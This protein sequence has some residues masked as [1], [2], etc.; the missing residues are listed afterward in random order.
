MKQFYPVLLSVPLFRG[1]KESDCEA[2]LKNLGAAIKKYPKNHIILLAGDPVDTLG[3]VLSGRVQIIKEDILGNRS[4]MAEFSAGDIFAESLACAGVKQSPVTVLSVSE[5]QIM[6]ISMK[7]VLSAEV[8]L[9]QFHELL[10][11]NMVHLLAEK[12]VYLNRKMEILSQK[13]I[14]EKVLAYLNEQAKRQKTM[15]PVI[16]FTREE[17]ADFLCVNRSALSKE[18]GRMQDE[19]LIHFQRNQFSLYPQKQEKA[20]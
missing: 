14:R 18:L 11:R 9:P 7:Q 8:S 13:S 2:V 17:L 10:I 12:N 3:I 4:I 20:D 6:H 15:N 1:L 5:S 19:H 16:P